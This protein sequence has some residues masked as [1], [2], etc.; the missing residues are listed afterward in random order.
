M[1]D[2][3][4]A[5]TI[6]N[7]IGGHKAFY[8]MGAK[9][10]G[11]DKNRL[12]FKIRGSRSINH[13]RVTLTSDDLYTLEFLYIT[14]KTYKTVKKLTGLYNHQLKPVIEE[15]TGLYLTL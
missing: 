12:S 4:I 3:E 8:M 5:M 10:L 6:Y 11:Y 14:V 15:E 7:Q 9:N 2:K 1:N 13:I